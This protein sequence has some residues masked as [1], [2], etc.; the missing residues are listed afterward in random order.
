MGYGLYLTLPGKALFSLIVVRKSFSLIIGRNLSMR[1][2]GW[3]FLPSVRGILVRILQ[4]THLPSCKILQLFTQL[5]LGFHSTVISPGYYLSHPGFQAAPDFL[6]DIS[7]QKPDKQVLHALR[8]PH[9]A[10]RTLCKY[11]MHTPDFPTF[12]IK[13]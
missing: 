3:H 4:P 1:D 9:V 2:H 13:V 8:R 10:Q 12:S 6:N 7:I 11:R 5:V